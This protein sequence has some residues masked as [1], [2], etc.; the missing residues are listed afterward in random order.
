M[1]LK[2]TTLIHATALLQFLAAMSLPIVSV[3]AESLVERAIRQQG[4][5]PYEGKRISVTWEENLEHATV[6]HEYCDGYGRTRVEYLMPRALFGHVL[7]HDGAF[8]WHRVPERH[9]V[10]KTAAPLP[11]E[12]RKR[13]ELLQTNY[14]VEVQ[15]EPVSSDTPCVL[16]VLRPK[17]SGKPWRRLWVEPVSGVILKSERY[18]ADNHLAAV[19]HLMMVNLKANIPRSLFSLHPV[20]GERVIEQHPQQSSRSCDALGRSISGF[21]ALPGTLPGNY[22]LDKVDLIGKPF[23][24]KHVTLHYSDGLSTLSIVETIDDPARRFLYPV[25]QPFHSGHTAVEMDS[26]HDVRVARW[27]SGP[28][29]FTLLGDVSQNVLRNIAS[30]L[31]ASTPAAPQGRGLHERLVQAADILILLLLLVSA[32][33]LLVAYR[34]QCRIS[35]ASSERL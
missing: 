20:A 9:V 6:T 15:P 29:Q 21:A 22:V 35:K 24:H 17:M 34:R 11:P 13:W 32:I 4:H 18:R 7:I 8:Q 1:R 28:R 19:S 3:S 14:T 25:I 27:T 26:H 12:S 2:P 33:S 30:E 16:I 23:S 31:A 5:I 10:F